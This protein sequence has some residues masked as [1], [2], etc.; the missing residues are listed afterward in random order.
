ML[1]NIEQIIFIT[2]NLNQLNTN[3]KKE[4]GVGVVCSI[5]IRQ[6]EVINQS[7]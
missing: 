6:D 7:H 5:C 3:L 2:Y 4:K 1:I